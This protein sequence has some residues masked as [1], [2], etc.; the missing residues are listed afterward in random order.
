[1]VPIMIFKAHSTVG[2]GY[3]RAPFIE[4]GLDQGLVSIN[5]SKNLSFPVPYF[6]GIMA[7]GQGEH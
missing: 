5:G 3:T 2:G 7:Q 4:S 1:M 6:V